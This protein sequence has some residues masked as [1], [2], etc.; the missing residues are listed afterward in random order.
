MLPGAARR[1]GSDALIARN[2]AT[3]REI[4]RVAATPVEQVAA[5]VEQA[6]GATSM[7]GDPLAAAPGGV[8]AVLAT[9]FARRRRLVVALRDEIGKPTGEALGGDVIATLDALRWLIRHGCKALKPVALSAGI[10]GS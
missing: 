6:R 2:P 4:G 8:E 9:S 5:L 3:G 10:N 7:G 1:M